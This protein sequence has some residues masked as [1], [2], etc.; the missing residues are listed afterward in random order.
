M[1]QFCKLCP[2]SEWTF[3]T[4]QSG[5]G[6]FMKCASIFTALTMAIL[7]AGVGMSN[8]AFANDDILTVGSPAPAIDV[9]H[10]VSHGNGRFGKVTEFEEGKV[11]VIEFWATWCGPCIASMPHLAELQERYAEKGVQLISISDEDLE[12]VQSFLERPVQNSEEE[13]LTYGKLTSVYSLTTDPDRSVHS[14]FMEAAGQ[15]GIPTAFIVGKDGIIEWIGHPMR[16]DQPLK[17]VV[18]GNWDR[19]A[20]RAAILPTQLRGFISA[21]ISQAMRSGD[22]EKALGIIKK[23]MQD[24]AD[25]S[26]LVAYLTR[27]QVQVQIFPITQLAQ[28]GKFEE[29][30]EKLAGLKKT[31]P[32]HRATLSEVEMSILFHAN[33][34]DEAAEVL[35]AIVAEEADPV[36]LNQ[37]SWM[38]Y[39]SSEQNDEF[40]EKL[41]A[42]AAAAAKK[43][44]ELSPKEAAI[45]D[46]YAH[47]LHR[48]G[49]LEKAVEVQTRAAKLAGD[50]LPDI[51]AFLEQLTKEKEDSQKSE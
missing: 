43:A 48:T 16:M 47:L 40:S 13:E 4:G 7:F 10:W 24:H 32:E 11:Y 19:D 38:I 2:F 49:D 31:V 34:Q 28:Q 51:K 12:T 30:L 39:Q 14:A 21:G 15:N 20:A 23:A 25:D 36:K 17:Q 1:S 29:A 22:S 18:E 5:Q 45:L 27:V 35:D 41:L 3:P 6:I 37:L 46:T 42:S 50:N 44:A 33:R 26:E 9:E 8:S